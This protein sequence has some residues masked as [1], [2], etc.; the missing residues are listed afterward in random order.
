M[1]ENHGSGPWSRGVGVSPQG[2]VAPG[3]EGRGCSRPAVWE[4]SE[5]KH[6]TALPIGGK[7]VRYYADVHK[8]A[9]NGE[10]FRITYTADGVT[11]RH[12]DG[13]LDI[14]AVAGDKVFVDV[15]PLHHTDG[16]IELLR[17]GVEV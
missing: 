10:G 6:N 4:A 1:M 9:K 16:V 14:P 15:L 13:F 17:H 3:F 7:G 12:V 5:G 2:R 11:F 8:K